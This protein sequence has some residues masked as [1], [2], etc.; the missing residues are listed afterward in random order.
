MEYAARK[1][2]SE[3]RCAYFIVAGVHLLW[4]G[5]DHGSNGIIVA[6]V[7]TVKSL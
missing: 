2:I 7:V 4:Y 1:T 6:V 3:M 5:S